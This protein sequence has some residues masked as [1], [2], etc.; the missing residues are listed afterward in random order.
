MDIRQADSYKDRAI[1]K[2]LFFEYLTWVSECLEKEFGIHVEVMNKVEEDMTKLDAFS[3]PTGRLLLAFEGE[4]PAGI[5]CLRRI[6][7]D[8]GEIKR[9]YVKPEFR[10]RGVGRSLLEALIA[11]AKGIGYPLLRLESARFMVSAQT[12]YQA[13]GF[14]LREPYAESEIPLEYQQHWVFM[15]KQIYS[16]V[17]IY[18]L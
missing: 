4:I 1:I 13:M 17:T 16:L 12:L 11:G 18:R 10:G 8:T 15:E 9:M 7:S 14:S 3:P 5:G 6:R 2:D